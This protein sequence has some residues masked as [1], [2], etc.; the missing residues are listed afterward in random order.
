MKLKVL[1]GYGNQ[2][3][4]F[5]AGTTID[6]DEAKAKSLMADSRESFEVVE[7]KPTK[8]VKKPAENKAVQSSTDK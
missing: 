8:A 1:S 3:E 4:Y 5:P 6:V 2:L 7:D